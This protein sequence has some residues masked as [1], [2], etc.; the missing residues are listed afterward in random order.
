[1]HQREASRRARL[2]MP[3]INSQPKL[4]VVN[5]RRTRIRRLLEKIG[6]LI[7]NYVVQR[8][9]TGYGITFRLLYSSIQA[10][11]I[12]RMGASLSCLVESVENGS[13][14]R[15]TMLLTNEHAGKGE[16][17]ILSISSAYAVEGRNRAQQL[18]ITPTGN[19]GNLIR[20]YIHL[21][22]LPHTYLRQVWC[23]SHQMASHR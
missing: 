23:R 2:S 22:W 13:T 8:A 3:A 17:G 10:K 6:S 18:K 5:R 21:Q 11:M 1:M 16:I 4:L 14:Y 20:P 9:K 12:N 7:V 19:T 15:V